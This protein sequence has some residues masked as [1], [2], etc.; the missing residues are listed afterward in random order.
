MIIPP[1][2]H[3]ARADAPFSVE[4]VHL[5]YLGRQWFRGRA[6]DS[7]DVVRTE[8]VELGYDTEA[9]LRRA[10]LDALDDEHV[11]AIAMVRTTCVARPGAGAAPWRGWRTRCDGLVNLDELRAVA[12]LRTLLEIEVDA[13]SAPASSSHAAAGRSR[14]VPER[15]REGSRCGP[16]CWG[17]RHGIGGVHRTTPAKR[18]GAPA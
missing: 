7:L 15:D 16:Q 6:D 4:A 17:C 1:A 3:E 5:W 2:T 14:R 11:V 18:T 13:E 9:T 12:A 10:A 8:P